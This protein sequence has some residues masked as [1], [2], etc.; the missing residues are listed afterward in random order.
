VTPSHSG[1]TTAP[2]TFAPYNNE[3]VIVSG[4]DV[5]ATAWSVDNGNV[6]KAPMSWDLGRGYNQV[7]VDGQ[8]VMEARWPNTPF[9][10]ILTPNDSTAQSVTT[11]PNTDGAKDRTITINDSALTQAAG[12]WNGAT[13]VLDGD[14]EGH[15]FGYMTGLVTDSKPGSLTAK[16]DGAYDRTARDG[17]PI[18]YHLVG[19]RS[20]L[21]Q[22]GEWVRGSDGNLYLWAPNGDNPSSHQVEAK[23]RVTAF[24]L[25]GKSWITVQGLNIFAANITTD[26]SSSHDTLDGIN[27]SYVFYFTL[28]DLK[29][30]AYDD[31]GPGDPNN[32]HTLDSGIRL[33]GSDM[34]LQNSTLAYS[35]NSIVSLTGPRGKIINNTIHDV[36]FGCGVG[37]GAPDFEVSHNT[38]YNNSEKGLCPGG[39]HGKV[40]YND[41]YKSTLRVHDA[42]PLY[43]S[44]TKAN[45]TEIAYNWVH[46]SG[47]AQ[48]P[49]YVRAIYLDNASGGF[50]VH[51]NVTWNVPAGL[52]FN[53]DS[54]QAQDNKA[55]NNTLIADN[56]SALLIS[57]PAGIHNEVKNNIFNSG[58]VKD[59][60]PDISNNI[61]PGTDPQFV[62]AAN[63]N[64]HLKPGSP[65]IDKGLV[66]PPYTNGYIGSTP[67]IGAYES[68]G[69]NWTAGAN[70]SAV[71]PSPT[72]R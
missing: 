1:T 18:K 42:G 12:F 9:S 19:L 26:P 44:G 30:A 21:D 17:K 15:P 36:D 37:I 11:V 52:N 33:E 72:C 71:S 66:I 7:F 25:H 23:K 24:N 5:V 2:I 35:V 8:M 62:N 39:Q 28:T 46:D 49:L 55:Y 50:I 58:D 29:G 13:L 70:S 31:G 51:H 16:S 20:A 40:F 63:H 53:S 68:G 22:A 32:T 45:G 69:Q 56:E 54:R 67:D 65:G 10:G 41:I 57:P 4:A 61:Y 34:V 43:T 38:I 48:N 3:K 60:P 47:P 6:Y 64:F 59:S 27:A 14:W